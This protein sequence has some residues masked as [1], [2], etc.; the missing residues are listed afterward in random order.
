MKTQ[1]STVQRP[2]GQPPF[3]IFPRSF[4]QSLEA[5]V[6]TAGFIELLDTEKGFE[7]FFSYLVQVCVNEITSRHV[8]ISCVAFSEI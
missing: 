1:T 8:V 7:T 4:K 3:C 2:F 6:A 5:G